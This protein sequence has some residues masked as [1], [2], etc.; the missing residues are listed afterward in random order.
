[1]AE[2]EEDKLNVFSIP[3]YDTTDALPYQVELWR[4]PENDAVELVLAR[5]LNAYLALA[6]YEAGIIE[7]P[8]RR[9]TLRRG[10]R[11]IADSREQNP[12]R[13]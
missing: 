7:Y 4:A 9:V 11:I 5:A 12:P 2:H 3:G 6:I 1:M 13:E 8:G 10:R